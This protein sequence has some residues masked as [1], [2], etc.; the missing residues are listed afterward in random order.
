MQS[1]ECLTGFVVLCFINPRNKSEVLPKH[2]HCHVQLL[3]CPYAK[4]VQHPRV[5][6]SATTLQNNINRKIKS[7]ADKTPP[8]GTVHF[9]RLSETLPDSCGLL[10]TSVVR[11]LTSAGWHRSA[12]RSPQ[13]D[14]VSPWAQPGPK[15]FPLILKWKS[16]S[17][18]HSDFSTTAD[19]S[20]WHR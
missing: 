9:Q 15:G 2:L 3:F 17:P 1:C 12:Q 7:D 10:P 20:A 8:L 18:T 6:S 4:E 14:P 16:G 5:G 13:P 11:L 19:F